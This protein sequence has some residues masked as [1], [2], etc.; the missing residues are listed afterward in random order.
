[1]QLQELCLW[2]HLFTFM[3]SQ[4]GGVKKKLAT[5][6]VFEFLWRRSRENTRHKNHALSPGSVF[7]FGGSIRNQN[8]TS[9]YRLLFMYIYQMSH[10]T[11]YEMMTP[12]SR[13][14][15]FDVCDL[16]FFVSRTILSIIQL[17]VR[18]TSSPLTR[19]IVALMIS[20][21]SE[22]FFASINCISWHSSFVQPNVF[23]WMC[24]I[25]MLRCV[26]KCMFRKM[27][28]RTTPW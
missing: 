16:V 6:M 9:I 1:M 3:R 19:W 10:S 25:R 12:A 14:I 26:G 2:V 7:E 22:P 24:L 18:I 27:P 15:P 8:A 28:S 23:H 21:R 11:I 4:V 20:F 17:L 13:I 5:Q